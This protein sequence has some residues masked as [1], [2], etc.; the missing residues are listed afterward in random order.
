LSERNDEPSGRVEPDEEPGDSSLAP[1]ADVDKL[2]EAGL[3]DESVAESM[4]DP[5]FEPREPEPGEVDEVDE[6]E[7]EDADEGGEGDP[8]GKDQ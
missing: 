8:D 5:S 3:A 4:G 1:E 6:A 7:P 2:A